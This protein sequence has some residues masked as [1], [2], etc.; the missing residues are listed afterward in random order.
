M[1]V[2]EVS[3]HRG[4]SGPAKVNTRVPL[5]TD[6]AS[7]NINIIND[8]IKIQAYYFKPLNGGFWNLDQSSPLL[9]T[10]IASLLYK[11]YGFWHC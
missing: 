5:F 11:Y 8:S 4:N 7:K 10:G 2:S 6:G 3:D 1:A 9:S